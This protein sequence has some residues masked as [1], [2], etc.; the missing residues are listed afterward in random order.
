MTRQ[1]SNP[2][3]GDDE[4]ISGWVVRTVP[5]AGEG[6][7]DAPAPQS[8]PTPPAAPAIAPTVDSRPEASTDAD[9]PAEPAK[10]VPD[11]PASSPNSDVRWLLPQDELLGWAPAAA[12]ESAEAQVQSSALSG[13]KSAAAKLSQWLGWSQSAPSQAQEAAPAPAGGEGRDKA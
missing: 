5:P 2:L 13:F 7:R 4:S 10:P 9:K 6:G 1:G 11:A 12:Q 8:A 3:P